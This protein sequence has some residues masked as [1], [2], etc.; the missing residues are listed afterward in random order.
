MKEIVNCQ[1]RFIGVQR[2]KYGGSVTFVDMNGAAKY[3]IEQKSAQDVRN[4]M[5]NRRFIIWQTYLLLMKN[6]V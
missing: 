6:L 1:M 2:K 3:Q 5:E 4:V